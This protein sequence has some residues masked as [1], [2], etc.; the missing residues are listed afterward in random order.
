MTEIQLFRRLM[1]WIAP[2][3]TMFAF[4]ISSL[5]AIALTTSLLPLLIKQ[6]LDSVLNSKN[7][8]EG[9]QFTL[10]TI[11]GLL[12]IRSIASFSSS[13]TI[14]W[15]SGKVGMDL[16]ETLFEKL[17][18]LPV[19]YPEQHDSDKLNAYFFSNIDQ[20]TDGI[21][22]ILAILVKEIFIVI[23]LLI[24]MFRVNWEFSLM[25][26]LIML[27]IGSIMQLVSQENDS[28][29]R[30]PH[31]SIGSPL[32]SLTSIKHIKSIKLDG[33]QSQESQHFCNSIEHQRN[34]ILK[35]AV[36]K[37]FSKT[38]ALIIITTLLAAFFFLFK[39]Q[40]NLHM[41]T[42]GDTGAMIIAALMLVVPI[43]RLL[44]MQLSL[45]NRFQVIH[46]IDSLLTQQNESDSGSVEIARTRGQLRFEEVSVYNY[47]Q[48][49]PP[50]FNLTLTIQ[51]SEIVAL[52]SSSDGQ[53]R[54]LIDLIARFIHPSEGR[55]LLDNIDIATIKLTDLRANI[56]WLTPDTKLLNDT[57][58][59]NIAYGTTRCATEASII[60]VARTCH[61]TKFA[62]GMPYG[63]QTRIDTKDIELSENQ[64]Q[65]ILIARALL[66]NPAIVIIDETTAVFNTHC[67]LVDDALD[68]LIRHRTTLIISPRA[69]MLEKAH[70]IL[71][72][73]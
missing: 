56:A 26:L 5:I 13:Y 65:C 3:W 38:I 15:I 32:P 45:Q 2:Y 50:L 34:L 10:L 67:A 29:Q 46:H 37:T 11:L 14:N 28:N 70:R 68:N 66:K 23:G 63:L 39:Q 21:T 49:C 72:L 30:T 60:K 71:E 55:I 36:I 7:D 58:A 31:P 64:R 18:A 9:F 54:T 4:A 59:A 35:Q 61:V 47:S 17:L 51:P 44:N 6:L 62:R 40:L 8:L 25:E 73:A 69:T 43:R 57:I 1:T 20:V 24:V 41:M 53:E 12:I 27:A 16:R 52:A 42:A 48:T 33:S 19:S 22:Q